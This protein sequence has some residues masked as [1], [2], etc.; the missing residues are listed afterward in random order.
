MREFFLSFLINN[1]ALLIGILIFVITALLLS[2]N[3]NKPFYGEHDWNGARYGNI[4]R[5]YL[6]YSFW[7][8]KFGQIENSG[9]TSPENFKYFTH[10][11]PVLPILVS[12]SYKIFN[13]SE[14]S[15]RLVPL[16][17][18]S[19]LMVIIYLIGQIVSNSKIGILA[20]LLVLL[21]PQVLYF[22]KNPVHEPLVTFFV[23]LALI[24]YL[25]Y[26]QNKL[27][28]YKAIFFIGIILAELTTWAG[29]FLL[30]AL[31]LVLL[32]KKQFNQIKEL[33]PVYIV[34][35]G[36]FFLHFMH[37]YFLTGQFLGG[38]LS[39]AFL[40]RAGLSEAGKIEGLNF[41][42]YIDRIRLWFSSLYGTVLLLLSLMWAIIH[43]NRLLEKNNWI[44]LVLFVFGSLYI[45]LFPNSSYIHNYLTF[46][47]LPFIAI[48]S[49]LSLNY[50]LSLFTKAKLLLCVVVF[51]LVFLE[52]LN[53]L[54]ALNESHA[55]ELAWMV[56]VEI[57]KN[58]K[59]NE[60]I[61]ITP[62]SFIHSAEKFLL[63]YSD[64]NL[65]YSKDIKIPKYDRK[66]EVDVSNQTIKLL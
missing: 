7:E 49:A 36:L 3:L 56:G 11:P 26:A 58:T 37:T 51:F 16:L 12:V 28:G 20:S 42:S 18:T 23:S 5:N 39:G 21:T 66:V 31:T 8:T 57:N 29:Y 63:F 65:V 14:W 13:I 44:V 10:Y 60:V 2:I 64:R 33:M 30:P 25:K 45:I 17:F 41:F 53:K 62:I 47:L 27:P 52:G 40:Q 34:S 32:L 55:D 15:T 48:S 19:G 43:Y 24:G 9:F 46:Y 54:T 6:R 61:L 50:C 1:N 38:D 35:F 59:P 4:A 22:G